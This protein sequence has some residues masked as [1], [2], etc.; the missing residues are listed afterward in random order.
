M[1]ARH[2]SA[3]FRRH[4]PSPLRNAQFLFTAEAIIVKIFDFSA[5]ISA[6]RR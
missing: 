1:W 4:F 3:S 6:L 5:E 2:H